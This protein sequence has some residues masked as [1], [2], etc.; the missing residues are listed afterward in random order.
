LRTSLCLVAMSSAA[1]NQAQE[2][3]LV[4]CTEQITSETVKG[5]DFNKGADLG[6]VLESYAR[7]GFQAMHYGQ[8]V[9]EIEKM[10]SWSLAED[11]VA[12]DEDEEYQTKEQREKVRTKIWLAYT[13]NLISSGV[14]ESI[15]FLAQH[16]LVQVLV[17]TAGGVEEDFIKCLA[18]TNLGDFALDGATLRRKG[19]NRIGNLLVSN[20]NYVKFE[21]W[22]GAILDKMHDEQEEEMAKAAAAKEPWQPWTPCR[23][24]HR[25]GKEIN[26]EESV[27]YWAWKNNIPVYCPALTDGS[28]GDMLYFHSY[29]RPGFVLDLVG[30]IRGV[31]DQAI[32][33][34]K[35]GVIIL[36]GG[37]V[38]HHTMNA[39]LMRNGADF[40][41]YVNVAGEFDGSDSGA[42]PDEAVSWGKIKVDAT[43]VKIYSEATLVF[44]LL[45][46]QTFAKR[47]HEGTSYAQLREK[48]GPL[49]FDKSLTAAEQEQARKRLYNPEAKA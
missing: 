18:P 48:L 7:V 28:I 47:Y 15:R 17:S 3:V 14:R 37:V 32:R 41:V 36:G 16:G 24:I 33:A 10:L 4:Q 11:P 35:S 38:K 12:P 30:D 39:N 42:R 25:L 2:A 13:S 19:W 26:N 29:K 21:E 44:P 49:Q 34:R 1:P 31:N 45:V 27:Y 43:P 22:L 8:A 9:K 20:D 23:F 5:H 6:A 46:A 40:C